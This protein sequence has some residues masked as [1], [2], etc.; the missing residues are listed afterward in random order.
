MLFCSHFMAV[1][2]WS[3][4][5]SLNTHFH[6]FVGFLIQYIYETSQKITHNYLEHN[7]HFTKF[8]TNPTK[9]GKRT[10]DKSRTRPTNECEKEREVP[11]PQFS[12]HTQCMPRSKVMSQETQNP[13]FDQASIE[14]SL[15]KH[16]TIICFLA[17]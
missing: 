4:T 10:K 17:M 14:A 1:C 9:K 15:M 7:Q 11:N 6:I 2:L 5:N 16:G 8:K 3:F 13:M 12:K